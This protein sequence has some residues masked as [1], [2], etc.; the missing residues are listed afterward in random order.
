[1]PTLKRKNENGFFEYIQLTGQDV[2]ELSNKIKGFL[3][4]AEYE[5]VAD[6]VADAVSEGYA[7]NWGWD[8]KT[9]VITDTIPNFHKVKHIGNAII[10]RGSNLFYLSPTGTQRNKIYVATTGASNTRLMD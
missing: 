3:N 7:L 10:Q 1:M 8:N 5:T 6:A 2:A 9:F 4:V